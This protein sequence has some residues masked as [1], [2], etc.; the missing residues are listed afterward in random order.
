MN[1]LTLLIDK[2]IRT[3]I[4]KFIEIIS[5]KYK[6]NTLDLLTIWNNIQTGNKIDIQEIVKENVKENVKQIV[7][8]EPDIINTNLKPSKIK[9]P[10]DNKVSCSYIF[11]KGSNEG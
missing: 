8:K 3:E 6:L 5:T 10:C 9:N 7:E 2:S 1:N 11:A 4:E